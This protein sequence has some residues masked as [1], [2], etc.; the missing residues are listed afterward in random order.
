MAL[1]ERQYFKMQSPSSPIS[2][3]SLTVK[4]AMRKGIKEKTESSYTLP[5]N[6]PSQ[7]K[8]APTAT[9]GYISIWKAIGCIGSQCRS[10]AIGGCA[11]MEELPLQSLMIKRN[12]RMPTPHKTFEKVLSKLI[13]DYSWLDIDHYGEEEEDG[14]AIARRHNRNI[15]TVA[16]KAFEAGKKAWYEEIKFI[17]I[18]PALEVIKNDG[19][20]IKGNL[21]LEKDTVF[22][23]TIVVRG[24]ILGKDGICDLK[25]RGDTTTCQRASPKLYPKSKSTIR[26]DATSYHLLWWEFR[27]Y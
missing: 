17:P 2:K 4:P 1:S 14:C 22:D 5:C 7:T 27:G 6:K 9:N 3:R 25:V 12:D 11:R 10:T 26:D 20:T 19:I 13:E 8:S 15:K 16:I 21:I 24:S 23:D 18:D